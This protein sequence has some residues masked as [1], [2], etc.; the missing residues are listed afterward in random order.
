[1]AIKKVESKNANKKEKVVKTKN[2]EEKVVCKECGKKYL[3]TLKE[4]P[5]CGNN[6]SLVVKK[7]TFFDDDFEEYDDEEKN[8]KLSKKEVKVENKEVK[9]TMKEEVTTKKNKKEVKKEDNKKDNKKDVNKKIKIDSKK[10]IFDGENKEILNFIK[11]LAV[12]IV[13]VVAVWFVVSLFN[14]ELDSN[15]D[16]DKDVIETIQNDKIL[17]SSIFDKEDNIYYVFAYNGDKDNSWAIYYATLF[18]SYTAIDDDEK[19]PM[20]WVDLSDP[21]NKDVVAEKVDDENKSP[22]KYENLSI[23]SPALIRIKNGKLDKYYDGDYAIDKMN[24]LIESYRKTE[25]K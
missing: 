6:P 2:V 12:I 18:D 16:D 7:N 22:S 23:Y 13:L 17:A 5:K 21:L 15:K 20:Y 8:T 10:P 25:E 19:V 4:C 3:S 1:M 24:R 14:K 9:E 11:I